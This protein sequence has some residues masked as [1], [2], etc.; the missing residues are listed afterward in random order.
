M[1]PVVEF[2]QRVNRPRV[3]FA[4]VS[5]W[6]ITENHADEAASF[7]RHHGGTLT[8]II[9]EGST[10]FDGGSIDWYSKVE[11]RVGGV[12]VSTTV[13]II[14]DTTMQSAGDAKQILNFG[15]CEIQPR[16]T[17]KAGTTT[18]IKVAAF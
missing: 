17:S 10:D 2:T 16:M 13:G 14:P 1:A 18:P 3:P 15:E 5:S 4:Q 12:V 8:V 6:E 7:R 11:I 9:D